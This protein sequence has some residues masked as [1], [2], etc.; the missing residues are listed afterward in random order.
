MWCGMVMVC[1]CVCVF[2]GWPMAQWLVRACNPITTGTAVGELQ[3]LP[4]AMK[5]CPVSKLGCQALG[6]F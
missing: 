2:F 5:S 1:V 6:G 4:V 3:I